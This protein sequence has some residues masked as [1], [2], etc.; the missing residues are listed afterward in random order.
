MEPLTIRGWV[1]GF[2]VGS[3][4]SSTG[5]MANETGA[6]HNGRLFSCFS[7]NT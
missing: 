1:K 4:L 6:E 2:H 5:D 3:G 7:H